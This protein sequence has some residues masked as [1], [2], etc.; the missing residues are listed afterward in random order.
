MDNFN[1]PEDIK[2]ESMQLVTVI[3]SCITLLATYKI[4]KE[5]EIDKK[6]KILPM[7]LMAFYP[8][9]IFLSGSINNDCLEYLFQFFYIISL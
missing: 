5:L 2:L 4:L 6:Y 9:N 1:L 8:L 3:Y 7:I